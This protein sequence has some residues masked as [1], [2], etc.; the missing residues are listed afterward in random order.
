AIPLAADVPP[1]DESP[2]VTVSPFGL[3][4]AALCVAWILISG[5]LLLRL[6]FAWWELSRLRSRTSPADATTIEIC[7]ALAPQLG[8]RAPAVLRSPF[9]Q[10]P[11]LAGLR[12]AA[13][14]LP[15]EQIELP[16]RDVLIH[17]LAHL[18]RHDCH[19]K[20]LHKLATSLFFFQPLAWKLARRIDGTSE[21][22]C[23]DYVMQ[24]GGDR[25]QYAHGLVDV[26]ELSAAPA[27]A[28]GAVG[29]G[30]VSLRS[31][32]AHRVAR[33][34]D[35]SRTLST[36]VGSL[37]VALV[38][39]GGLI[40]TGVVGLVGLKPRSSLAE[41]APVVTGDEDQ[42]A[43]LSADDDETNRSAEDNTP[44]SIE[45]I[46][47]DI[48]SLKSS[49]ITEPEV[50]KATPSKPLYGR[51]LSA[52]GKP[53]AG[54][55]F[56][57]FRSRVHDLD[58]MAP[59][60][61]ATSNDK[62]EFKFD[63]PASDASED[64]P[65]GWAISERIVV[66]AKGHGFTYTGPHELQVPNDASPLDVIA[67]ASER[68]PAAG[69]P[70]RGRLVN[71]DGQPIAGARVRVRWFNDGD[72]SLRNQPIAAAVDKLGVWKERVNYLL[73]VIE[74]APLRD[75]LPQATTDADG[76]FVLSDLGENRL[77]QLLVEG[78]GIETTEIVAHN[79]SAEEIQIPA[80]P[81]TLA[82]ARTI[83]GRNFVR[84]I[85]PSRP[86]EG[87]V[88]DIDTGAPLAGAVVR[89]V[90]IHGQRVSTS[91]E[92]EEFATRTD[93][94]GRYRITGLPIGDG[95]QLVAFTTGADPYVAIG[96]SVD[97]SRDEEKTPQDFRLKRGVWVEGRVF[98]AASQQPFTGEISYY[99]F[100]D[101]ELKKAVPG[102]YQGFV[103]GLYWTNAK[104]E[105]RIPVLPARGILGYRYDGSGP[106]RDG[107]DRYPR[108]AGAEEIAGVEKFGAFP[109]APFYMMPGSYER[110][111]EIRP[112]H[113][114]A[115][116]R[117]DI[118]LVASPPVNVRVV[119][120]EGKPI[121]NYLLYGANERALWRQTNSAEVE[122]KDL[123]PKE[124]RKLLAFDRLRNLAGA[125]SVTFGQTEIAQITLQKAGS[126]V[127]VIVDAD[128]T[129]ITDVT[130]KP[131]L[132][133]YR[134][135]D[136]TAPWAPVLNQP[137]EPWNAK[138]DAKG[139]F[140]LDGL[141]PGM[142]YNA[143]ASAPRKFQG[144]L[145]DFIIGAA[146]ID[147]TVEPGEVK[148]L[149]LVVVQQPNME[150][151]SSEST[152]TESKSSASGSSESKQSAA[153]ATE[154]APS[155]D[156]NL[157]YRG[158]VVDPQERPVAGAK[159][160]LVYWRHGVQPSD[161]LKPNATTDA[162]GRFDF[163]VRSGD[164][165]ASEGLY[166]QV[167]VTAPGFGL[168]VGYSLD[169]ETTGGAMDR[170]PPAQRERI[171]QR[172][173]AGKSSVFKLPV[174]SQPITG[175]VVST[176]G[177]PVVGARVRVKDLWIPKTENLDAF[178]QAAK[179]PKA[180]YYSLRSHIGQ[181]V[182]GKQLPSI[183]RDVT[184]DKDG[185]F[186]FAGI[187]RDRVVELMITGP[188]IETTLLHARTRAG[189]KIVVPNQ[190][191]GDVG[192]GEQNTFLPASFVQVVGPS[193][194]IVG[195][196]VDA[197]SGK[198]IGGA[199]ISAGEESS[200]TRSGKPH[201]ATRSDADGSFRL[202]GLG[203]DSE[204][205]I[206]AK[207]PAGTGLLPAGI[208]ITTENDRSPP[209]LNFKVKRGVWVRGQAIDKRTGEPVLGHVNYYSFQDNPHLNAFE[210]FLRA[211]FT[212]ES[213]TNAQ[214]RF[215][216][217]VP[218]GSGILTFS[219]DNHLQFRRGVGA[220]TISG[221]VENFN[222]GNKIFLTVP[223]RL[224]STNTHYLRQLDLAPDAPPLEDLKLELN[225]GVDV[226]GSIRDPEGN[227]LD[228]VIVSGQTAPG[229]GWDETK[230]GAFL[231][232]G[233]Y[234]AAPRDLYFFD[235][236]RNLA[237][238]QRLSGE[239]PAKIEVTLQ[240]AGSLRGRLIEDDG[241]PLA[242][243]HLIG[244]GV[245][246]SNFGS[247]DLRLATDKEG[248]FLIQGLLPGRK[249]TV[250]A[251][252]DK[253]L[254]RAITGA[255]VKAGE[256]H[257]LG[258]LKIQPLGEMMLFDPPP[259]EET[260]PDDKPADKPAESGA[261]QESKSA[262]SAPEA[263]LR[264]IRGR[265]VDSNDKPVAGAHVAAAAMKLSRA[266]GGFISAEGDILAE[267]V[268]D[269][270]GEF[271]LQFAPTSE[272]SHRGANVLARADG[273]ALGWT[274]I[275]PD[276]KETKITIKLQ[277]EEPI[278]GRLV[279]ID[280]KPASGV[281]YTVRSLIART[282]SEDLNWE[283][284]VGYKFASP[285][286]VWFAPA[287]SDAEGRFVIHGIP[288]GYG[289]SLDVAG[290][291]Q[292]APQDL[293]L[294]TGA[295]EQRGERDATYRSLVKNAAAGEEAIVPLAPAQWFEGVVRYEDTGEPAPRAR[296]KIWAS[297]QEIGSMSTVEGVADE[298]GRYRIN[299]HPGIR[300]GVTA[301]PPEG[302]PY[303][304]RRTPFDSAI[305]WETGDRVK[306]IDK[307][308]KRG[309]ALRGTVV[310]AESGAPIANASVQYIPE[311]SNNPNKT[312]DIVTGWEG[313]QS[314]DG[315]G[316]FQIVVLPGPGRLLVH[317]PDGRHILQE[318]G[319]R[320]L[321]KS[322]PGGRRNFAH[323]IVKLDPSVDKQ[324][325]P[326]TI[327]LQPGRVV[328]GRLVD[329]EGKLV[330]EALVISPLNIRAFW[331]TWHGHSETTLR[332]E[333]E[334][335]GLAEDQEYLFYFLDSKRR[336][337]TAR[338]IKASDPTPNVVLEP[339][340]EATARYI[341][342]EGNP[343]KGHHPSLHIVLKP[344][345]NGNDFDAQDKGALAAMVDFVQNVDRVNHEH[346]ATDADGQVVFPALIPGATYQ[347]M[348]VKNGK[349]VNGREF[350]VTAGQKLDLGEITYDKEQ[351]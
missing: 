170:L 185:R 302:A 84:A 271:T 35:T 331:L 167:V 342:S 61:I 75:T 296:V 91:R 267:V 298:N 34:M 65:A 292:F 315:Q 299:P 144:V 40:G 223:V 33:I 314:T 197:D 132:E 326:L 301:Y 87:R 200:T 285:Q 346:D 116:T 90:L 282:K 146:L 94:E 240:P 266:A 222:Q 245:P 16:I 81:L 186:T 123:K 4:E 290:T 131:N 207:A 334:I 196:I 333:F 253:I 283:G 256:T 125:T 224:L 288:P 291:E 183:L 180:D 270:S 350:K 211:A 155:D 264:T 164:L 6:G 39:I 133:K 221:P 68:L 212:H 80:D 152:N 213:R 100:L 124:K 115:V 159:I 182:N 191:P 89:A 36:R 141:V 348:E 160:L 98:D 49:E 220:E 272:K 83:Y 260:K 47:P 249:Y 114:Q 242:G 202:T 273:L 54:A 193:F 21:E 93:A 163:D 345:V 55:E 14:L 324:P 3:I 2:S 234:A 295:P 214:G 158:Q 5:G 277:P 289:V 7:R 71:I 343:L 148:D 313:I 198:A 46:L 206:F 306:Q 59:R 259:P 121:L 51:V 217:A 156:L 230:A 303:L 134:D 276:V 250:V 85:G 111:V 113:D 10:S 308:L 335:A 231:V 209:A 265:V 153:V 255:T 257:D 105:F 262:A 274:K 310:D 332:G 86:I 64:E 293:L 327:Q 179:K 73:N 8:V 165:D 76:R 31:M 110:V 287:S 56:Y 128:K 269:P 286:A 194:P 168:A 318:I 319:S 227:L 322:K 174:D 243:I 215:E 96:H 143:H 20:L 126:V 337:G 199:L 154:K 244:A 172:Q 24:L 50:K 97:T 317:D 188:E 351:K 42:A 225:S 190:W 166:A 233:Y 140:R 307:T 27:A 268:S 349:M 178:E 30:I 189:E 72:E 19:W 297:Q 311:S 161:E 323:A 247:Q 142:K 325:E 192:R 263:D 79:Q 101:P 25:E 252:T 137:V 45:V 78:K 162:E 44:P 106:D 32:L 139:R 117:A 173:A 239:P 9:V 176:E 67:G 136:D 251:E 281:S 38:L 177:K 210:G 229:G 184:T 147:V 330:N 344:G 70:I 208:T 1:L 171:R 108:G 82:V 328:R 300:F 11:C 248:R 15:D 226:A 66:R 43:L 312:D 321:D 107:V 28:V 74:P 102:I 204:E 339:C 238:Y 275:E 112:A 62:G 305:D 284:S 22:V 92:R 129:P 150:S 175:Q 23:D 316:A 157:N 203:A 60:L 340:G 228:G 95:N 103:D 48:A 338:V 12:R 37:L 218:P 127:G 236:A 309:V 241:A 69:E 181:G 219:P 77:V 41:V 29:V 187:G 122:V 63:L 13:V 279:D 201:I 109:T 235:P 138:V 88:T 52:K 320:D 195:Q 278:R 205:T 99:F 145:Q 329:L 151:S 149:G 26:A 130:L 58:P 119:D 341:D 18:R 232:R 104:G 53:I 336:L 261:K 216:I 135:R 237:A 347:F 17:E 57:W 294:N 118:R 246:G 120:A 254:G 169:I 258:D 304:I 280:G